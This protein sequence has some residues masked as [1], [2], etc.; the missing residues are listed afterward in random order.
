MNKNIRKILTDSG[1][2]IDKKARTITLSISR[3]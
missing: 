2:S 1:L 3:K